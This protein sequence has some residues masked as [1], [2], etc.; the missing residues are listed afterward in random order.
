LIKI[1]LKEW[2]DI[3]VLQ[4]FRENPFIPIFNLEDKS[5]DYIEIIDTSKSGIRIKAKNYVGFI[6]LNDEYLLIV[7][8]KAKVEDFLY[9]LFKAKGKRTKL[10]DFERIVET[11]RKVKVGLEYPNI[12]DFLLYVLLQELKKIRTLGFLKRSVPKI[13][14]RKNIRG[15]ILVKDTI[16]RSLAVGRKTQIFCSYYDLSKNIPE[17][18]AI[19]FTLWLLLNLQETPKAAVNEFFDRYRYFANV[20]SISRP[21]HTLDEVE[22]RIGKNRIPSARQYYLDILN[23]CIFFITHSKLEYVTEKKVKLRAFIIDM[24]TIFEEYV[25]HTLKDIVYP[26][27]K[28]DK[29]LKPLFDNRNDFSTDPD[30]LISKDNQVICI[31]DAKYK[32]KPSSDDFYQ[33]F[34]YLDVYNSDKGILVYPHFG[35]EPKEEVFIRDRKKIWIYRL[36]LVNLREAEKDIGSFVRY[37]INA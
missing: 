23:L 27:F 24:N 14:G 18:M 2:E 25:R 26:E 7:N 1:N 31:G 13:E 35:N 30:Y 11:G 4:E 3:G 12:F 9:M 22:D 16:L 34:T 5:K 33:I 32:E 15:K 6:P 36:N 8:P 17:N 20:D 29:G 10:K 19:K 21:Q 28:I 37:V